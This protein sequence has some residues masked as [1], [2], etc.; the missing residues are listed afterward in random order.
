MLYIGMVVA[1]LSLAPLIQVASWRSLGRDRPFGGAKN[2][3]S[4]WATATSSGR[5]VVGGTTSSPNLPPAH[6]EPS[7]PVEA[8]RPSSRRSI[9]PCP[10]AK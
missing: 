4:R 7:D 3:F 5:A 1:A 9:S 2:E 8:S 10:A 6:F